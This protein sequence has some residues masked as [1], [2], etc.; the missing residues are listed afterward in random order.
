MFQTIYDVSVD[1]DAIRAMHKMKLVLC[2]WM[3]VFR[4]VRA[5]FH[6]PTWMIL[7]NFLC[8]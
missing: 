4:I 6:V 5:H 7:C 1:N 2:R 8:F 3:Q